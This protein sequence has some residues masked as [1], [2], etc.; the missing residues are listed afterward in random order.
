MLDCSSINSHLLGSSHFRLPKVDTLRRKPTLFRRLAPSGNWV[1]AK[2]PLYSLSV[3]RAAGY[4]AEGV[5]NRK[6]SRFFVIRTN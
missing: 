3:I 4:L 2:P 6:I 5:A 1:K